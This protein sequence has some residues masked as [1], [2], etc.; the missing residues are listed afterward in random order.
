MGSKGSQMTGMP[1]MRFRKSIGTIRNFR[2]SILMHPLTCGASLVVGW[3]HA[4]PTFTR[5]SRTSG[6]G[7]GRSIPT[8]RAPR[9]K[10]SL[11]TLIGDM[12]PTGGLN[13]SRWSEEMSDLLSKLMR[14][15]EDG[16]GYPPGE[17]R[18]HMTTPERGS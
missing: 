2:I 8:Q 5:T 12:V 17:N 18:L 16:F 3:A 15:F 14:N 9:S 11:Q 7:S 6:H 1:T 10:A 4:E 13:L